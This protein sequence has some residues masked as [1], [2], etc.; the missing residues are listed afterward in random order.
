MADAKL[1]PCNMIGCQTLKKMTLYVRMI[2]D[3][4]NQGK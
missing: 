4:L 1:N 3:D 2:G